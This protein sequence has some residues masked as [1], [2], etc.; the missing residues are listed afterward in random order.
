MRLDRY[1]GGRRRY[2][3]AWSEVT[4]TRNSFGWLVGRV[5][6]GRSTGKAPAWLVELAAAVGVRQLE[7]AVETG[8]SPWLAYRMAVD[9][10]APDLFARRERAA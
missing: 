3:G 7:I 5:M 2:D 6:L 1:H 8:G 9:E 4:I 10:L